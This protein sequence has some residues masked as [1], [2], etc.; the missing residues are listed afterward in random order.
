MPL[1]TAQEFAWSLATTLMACIV[2]FEAG[3]ATAPCP[4]RS[5]TAIP[6]PSSPSSI[7]M[8]GETPGAAWAAP[9]PPIANY[10]WDPNPRQVPHDLQ[11]RKWQNQFEEQTS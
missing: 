4:R 11:P 8:S 1:S 5:S 9:F 3:E 2:V 10:T 6:P 7:R